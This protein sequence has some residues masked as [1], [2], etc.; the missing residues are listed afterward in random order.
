MRVP[1]FEISVEEK[2]DAAH[3]LR[4]YQGNCENLH[5]HTYR[6]KV[7]LRVRELGNIGIALDFKSVRASLREII[8]YLDHTFINDLPEFREVNPTAENLAR[9]IY[10]KM[11]EE[12]AGS[13]YKVKVWETESAA[14]SYWE[15][16]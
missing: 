5:G 16:E 10:G 13:L 8:T 11:K 12:Y 15:D 14:A 9:Y 7:K 2:F 1:M 4:G 3:C 6:V